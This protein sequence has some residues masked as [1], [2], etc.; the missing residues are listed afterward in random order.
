MTLH[1]VFNGLANFA[2][3]SFRKSFDTYA[4]NSREEQANII[5]ARVCSVAFVAASIFTHGFLPLVIF[6][7]EYLT[8]NSAQPQPVPAR[9]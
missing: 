1:D 9:A 5:A 6:G 8:R 4:N 2:K 7:G 3:Q